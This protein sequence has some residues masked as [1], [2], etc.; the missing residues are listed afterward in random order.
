M[1]VR[2]EEN[3]DVVVLSSHPITPAEWKQEATA[4]Y[5]AQQF[6]E[7][8]RCY[9]KAIEVDPST[10]PLSRVLCNISAV[11]LRQGDPVGALHAALASHTLDQSFAKS[12]LRVMAAL[13]KI[14]RPDLVAA[15]I[16]YC[17]RAKQGG[18]TVWDAEMRLREKK[19][20]L[21]V[22]YTSLAKAHSTVL[23]VLGR[24]AAS[25]LF[26]GENERK[27]V[28]ELDICAQKDVG[29]KFFTQDRLDD[30]LRAYMSVIGCNQA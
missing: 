5:R 30:A 6:R 1:I 2:V 18:A 16:E 20:A 7:A 15:A 13:E 14:D 3:A 19:H 4:H 23:D 21:N 9:A 25:L 29:N 26:R 12:D 28:P 8:D 24:D 17:K 10:H 27:D 22:M 11:L